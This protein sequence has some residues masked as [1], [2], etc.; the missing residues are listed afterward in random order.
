ML[1]LKRS[2]FNDNWKK[3]EFGEWHIS[4]VFGLLTKSCWLT[5]LFIIPNIWT[6]H[7]VKKRSVVI[8]I[9][10]ICPMI[11]RDKGPLSQVS[12]TLSNC[13]IKFCLRKS[14]PL[15]VIIS[16]PPPILDKPGYWTSP[17]SPKCFICTVA[18]HFG[19]CRHRQ[20]TNRISLSSEGTC[21]LL[22]FAS[23][24]KALTSKYSSGWQ[25]LRRMS[26]KWYT[27]VVEIVT[28][29]SCYTKSKVMTTLIRIHPLGSINVSALYVFVCGLKLP[30][31][32]LL[33]WLKM[34]NISLNFWISI[35]DFL[36][37]F[38]TRHSD[39]IQLNVGNVF[40]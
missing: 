36:F 1:S 35:F 7:R 27:N 5:L 14:A 39:R 13:M 33:V 26:C 11:E 16:N 37:F 9:E 3:I 38:D 19:K 2:I 8:L 21:A 15:S 31:L 40:F 29:W 23:I 12:L 17:C 10:I 28:C 32:E 24:N 6:Y 25:E 20:C 18:L 34:F 4:I 22:L 30:S